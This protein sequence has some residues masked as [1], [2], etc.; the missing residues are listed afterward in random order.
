VNTAKVS[1]IILRLAVSASMGAISAGFF[2]RKCNVSAASGTM[3]MGPRHAADARAG[4]AWAGRPAEQERSREGGD[5][6]PF[7]NA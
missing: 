7:L 4:K 1:W 2:P 3:R 6:T 5:A